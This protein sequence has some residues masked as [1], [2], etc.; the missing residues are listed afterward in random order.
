MMQ[1]CAGYVRTHLLCASAVLIGL[2]ALCGCGTGDDTDISDG[3][4]TE[5]EAL[6]DATDENGP[7]GT[8]GNRVVEAPEECDDG[9]NGN[10]GD[11]CTDACTFTCHE[12]TQFTDCGD[13]TDDCTEWHCVAGGSGWICEESN[14]A[15][16]CMSTYCPDRPMGRGT[17]RDGVCVCD[18]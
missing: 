13:L 1:S 12:L 4:D 11:G 7:G 10:A 8:C 16:E 2:V 9:A 18:S 15:G 14:Y 17:C 3:G 6:A 5:S